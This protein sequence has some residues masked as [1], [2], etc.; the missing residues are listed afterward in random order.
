M[1]VELVRLAAHVSWQQTRSQSQHAVYMKRAGGFDVLRT[2]AGPAT[3]E[4]SFAEGEGRPACAE[5]CRNDFWRLARCSTCNILT[6]RLLQAMQSAWARGLVIVH[7]GVPLKNAFAC[8]VNCMDLTGLDLEE[9]LRYAPAGGVG[10]PV[11]VGLYMSAVNQQKLLSAG[12]EAQQALNMKPGM[13]AAE[14]ARWGAALQHYVEPGADAAVTSCPHWWIG[15][16]LQD[17]KTMVHVDLC[18]VVYGSA[19][20]YQA[21]EIYGASNAGTL[22]PEIPISVATSAALVTMDA[23]ERPDKLQLLPS[24]RD[25]H[26]AAL[27]TWRAFRFVQ[28]RI[29]LMLTPFDEF[30]A[31]FFGEI[32]SGVTDA[33][34]DSVLLE[35]VQR[36]T[37]AGK[38][39]GVVFC[40]LRRTDLNGQPGRA[41]GIHVDRVACVTARA[42]GGVRVLPAK[43]SIH[44][45]P[46]AVPQMLTLAEM[47]AR[48]FHESLATPHQGPEAGLDADADLKAY[49]QADPLARRFV[50]TLRAGNC[51]WSSLTDP[52]LRPA[53]KWFA[54]RP[55]AAE[56]LRSLYALTL[57]PKF[58]EFRAEMSQARAGIAP[59]ALARFLETD[60]P[61]QRLYERAAEMG[62]LRQRVVPQA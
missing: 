28:K 38:G 36:V 45:L 5:E 54:E 17:E 24:T 53:L 6:G 23:P 48:P 21:L 13:T 22:P 60:T 57:M 15:C 50:A 39:V 61:F 42:E 40:G 8:N 56:P 11:E 41:V 46:D 26:A 7:E 49:V 14:A 25:G 19:T 30:A 34:V 3:P 29:P 10:V 62:L 44:P 31:R 20:T 52:E 12:T 4:N 47:R 16:E 9:T 33:A 51:G 37:S 27:P 1:E 55:T 18:G 59:E 32:P 43:I 35:T 58:D 2:E